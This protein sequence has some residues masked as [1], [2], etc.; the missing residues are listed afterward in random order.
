MI[1][2]DGVLM[3]LNLRLTKCPRC[4]NEEFSSD[5]SHCRICGFELYNTCD[6]ETICDDFGNYDHTEYHRNPGNARFCEKCG[7]KTY[8]FKEKILRPYTE[9]MNEATGEYFAK[10]PDAYVCST[11]AKSEEDDSPFSF[12]EESPFN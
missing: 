7:A 2:N 8:F 10:N 9:V 3:D 12:S 6:G 5:A 1:Y 4:G 11:E